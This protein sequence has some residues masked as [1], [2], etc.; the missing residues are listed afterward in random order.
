VGE[1]HSAQAKAET[2]DSLKIDFAALNLEGWVTPLEH[3]LAYAAVGIEVFPVSPRKTP[4]TEHGYLDA[5]TDL[6]AIR[7]WWGRWPAADI[8]WALPPTIVV[9]DLDEKGGFH[10]LR[11]FA[12]IAGVSADDVETPQATSPTGGRHLFY[13]ADGYRYKN[14]TRVIPGNGID[15]RAHGGYV[16]L[17][18][19]GNGR[20]WVKPLATTPLADAPDWVP[21]RQDNGAPQGSARDYLGASIFER[22]IVAVAT[23]AIRSAPNGEQEFTLHKWCFTIGG[24]IEG[25]SVE[26]GPATE[27]LN[28]AAWQ[29]PSYD[30]RRPWRR[31]A[32]RDKVEASIAKGKR[33]PLDPPQDDDCEWQEEAAKLEAE[34]VFAAI[35]RGGG[36]S[37]DEPHEESAEAEGD[38]AECEEADGDAAQGDVDVEAEAE[39]A[40]YIGK[41][42]DAKDKANRNALAYNAGKRLG[43]FVKAGRLNAER[44]LAEI[45]AAIESWGG[46]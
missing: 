4:L 9:I 13:S 20:A 37:K 8:G 27:A 24:L 14:N 28:R 19:R 30:M 26:E 40:K 31:E 25:G 38:E 46:P 39:L 6:E 3:A 15:T 18:M 23:D 41:L 5:V 29:M 16:V 34:V 35:E 1:N 21:Q 33:Y 42:R 2:C 7:A 17:P 32:L 36:G 44:V 45:D 11:D 22:A 12:E 43:R 10:G